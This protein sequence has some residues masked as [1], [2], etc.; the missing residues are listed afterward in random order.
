MDLAPVGRTIVDNA[1]YLVLGT[2]DADG[3]PWAAPVYFA[4]E[5]YREFIWVSKP[6]ARHSLNIEVRP[7]VSIVVFD[8]TV[9][10]GSGGGVYMEASAAE[11][12]EAEREAALATFSRRSVTHGGGE[13]SAAEVVPPARLRLYKAIAAEQ[14]VLDDRDNRVALT[15]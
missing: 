4:H 2:A 5:G 11:V 14:F 7:E 8:S 1:L 15:L 10:I 3:R 6:E 9:P 12:E 13:F